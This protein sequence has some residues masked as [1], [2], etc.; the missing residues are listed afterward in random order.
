MLDELA[1]ALADVR[2]L[3]SLFQT[4]AVWP[5]AHVHRMH[6]SR[7]HLKP[8]QGAVIQEHTIPVS[9]MLLQLT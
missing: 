5:H 8:E 9:P 6:A 7:L 4:P 3:Q 2:P 1:M